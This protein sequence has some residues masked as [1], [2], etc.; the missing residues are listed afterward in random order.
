M[1]Y[2]WRPHQQ[3]RLFA[4]RHLRGLWRRPQAGYLVERLAGSGTSLER[5]DTHDRE[6]S[7]A[8][9]S[10]TSRIHRLGVSMMVAVHLDHESMSERM[11][12]QKIHAPLPI[13]SLWRR[14]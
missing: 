3:Q 9:C 2:R 6:P 14:D 11:R 5:G 1:S 7:I 8:E 4:R 12:E 10:I 13:V